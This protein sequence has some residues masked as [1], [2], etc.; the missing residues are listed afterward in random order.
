M[1]VAGT[2]IGP[3]GTVLAAV[4]GATALLLYLDQGLLGPRIQLVLI[5]VTLLVTGAVV[6]GT[7]RGVSP[8]AGS[9][10][11]SPPPIQSGPSH[12]VGLKLTREELM[13]PGLGQRALRGATMDSL[14]LKRLNFAGRDLSGATLVGA[15]LRDTDLRDAVLRGA[16]LTRADL[17][18][19]CLDRADLS[20]ALVRLAKVAGAHLVGAT[21]PSTADGADADWR[22]SEP[23]SC[24]R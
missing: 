9:E 17:R 11:G 22:P 23:T 20:G 4:V 15:D 16:D 7:A 2:V 8:L 10:V 14:D 5:T 12:A 6:W 1:A 24:P 3:A 19:A 21:V 18:G 13:D